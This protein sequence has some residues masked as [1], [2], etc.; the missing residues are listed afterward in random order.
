[1]SAVS[2][3]TATRALH[4]VARLA[5]RAFPPLLARRV[6]VRF[7]RLL[8]PVYDELVAREL[9][10][11]LD[12]SGT[13]LSRAITLAARMPKAEVVIGV[14]PGAPRPYFAHAWVEVGG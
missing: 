4:L 3:P 1:M 8:P 13:C 9:A 10:E 12:R 11:L 14:N 5:I 2:A 6:V 7:A